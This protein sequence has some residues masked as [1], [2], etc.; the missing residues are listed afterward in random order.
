[1]L[2]SEFLSRLPRINKI[3]NIGIKKRYIYFILVFL[4]VLSFSISSYQGYTNRYH[5]EGFDDV[6]DALIYVGTQNDVE[7]VTVLTAWYYTGGYS[8]LH[9]D[10]ELDFYTLTN[11]DT[12]SFNKYMVQK[13]IRLNLSNYFV[14]PTY[15]LIDNNWLTTYLI[16]HGWIMTLNIED[17]CEVWEVNN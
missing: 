10:V 13:I 11:P 1:M 16:D 4:L 12:F 15:Q 7:S 2:I 5:V 9:L 6:N 17:R 14:L 8:Y 3:P